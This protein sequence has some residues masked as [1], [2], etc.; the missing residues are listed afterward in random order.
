[1]QRCAR[2]LILLFATLLMQGCSAV[3]LSY[4]NAP[5]L[6][7]WMIDDY[8]DL[9][10]EQDTLLRER[11]ARLHAWHR[12]TQLPDYVSAL[13]HTQQ[14]IAGQPKLDDAQALLDGIYRRGRTLAEQA[15]PDIAD[16]LLTTTAAQSERVA[17]HFKERNAS[18]AKEAQLAKGEG[19]Q[20][21]A[22]VKRVL[23]RSEY[24]F[25]D[26]SEAQQLALTQAIEGQAI[27]T[28]FWYDERL[29]RQREWLEL[30]RL[31][32]R[33]RPPRDRLI[34]LLHEYAARF[35]A[36]GDAVRLR[37][38]RALRRNSAEL[39]LRIHAM[40]TAKQRAHA[41]HKLGDLISDLTDL[42][43]QGHPDQ[44]PSSASAGQDAR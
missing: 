36:P 32:Q 6:L 9:T 21:K 28:Q 15:T 43:R 2:L 17:G 30:M 16:L 25:G 33:D 31:V 4:D 7:R 42:S 34:E 26:F 18:F 27:A 13:R 1:M 10:E 23:E 22:Q 8:A 20:R 38:E 40:T 5:S 39:I 19:A 35:D 12:K 3:R 14:L 41:Q 29:R 37:Q 44:G 24:W 11:L